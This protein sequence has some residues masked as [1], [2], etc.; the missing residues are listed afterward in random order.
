[1]R[2]NNNPENRRQ[3]HT[4]NEQTNNQHSIPNKQNKNILNQYINIRS[5]KMGNQQIT[6]PS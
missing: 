3:M 1:M 5:D 4:P 2:D 6:N